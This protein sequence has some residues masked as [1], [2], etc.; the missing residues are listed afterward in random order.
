MLGA[1]ATPREPRI[2]A[3][4]PM[5]PLDQELSREMFVASHG[6]G[7]AA[8]DRLF[9]ILDGRGAPGCSF[10]LL[11]LLVVVGA[12]VGSAAWVR[13]VASGR[14]DRPQDSFP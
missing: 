2:V 9:A 10:V 4:A 1:D 7:H 12:N 8:R 14:G 6:G 5:S 11:D 3:A 13:R